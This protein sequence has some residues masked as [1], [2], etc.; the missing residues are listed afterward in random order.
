MY[1]INVVRELAKS[2]IK[3]NFMLKHKLE[4]YIFER[5]MHLQSIIKK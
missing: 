4:K 3:S 5:K 2:I 1:N